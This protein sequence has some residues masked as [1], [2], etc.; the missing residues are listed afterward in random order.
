[1]TKSFKKAP[2]PPDPGVF[3]FCVSQGMVVIQQKTIEAFLQGR[4]VFASAPTGAG[5]SLTFE[6]APYTFDRLLGEDCD[7]IVLVIVPLTSL[8]KDQVSS[9]IPVAYR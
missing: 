8:M 9:L 6:L 7:A 1:M 3:P 2:F 4:D 5:K